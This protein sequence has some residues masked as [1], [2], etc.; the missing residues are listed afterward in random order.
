MKT[1]LSLLALPLLMI[2]LLT[3]CGESTKKS[4]AQEPE[5][6]SDEELIRQDLERDA[7]LTQVMAIHDEVMPK[8]EDIMKLKSKLKD[9]EDADEILDAL[10]TAEK[11]MMNWMR[12]FKAPSKDASFDQT[13]EY[14]E[15]QRESISQV[16]DQ[17]LEA[18]AN[19]EM[20]L[21]N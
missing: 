5:Q 13:M 8:M 10:E 6:I 12:N 21:E 19:A 18:I 7:L 17:M 16:R 3:S 20:A 9:R 15:A 14:L 1:L 2:A 11:A 4:E